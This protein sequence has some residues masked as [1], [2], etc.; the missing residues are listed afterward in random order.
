MCKLTLTVAI[1]NVQTEG[2][3]GVLGPLGSPLGA[4][5]LGG[6]GRSRDGG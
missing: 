5:G 4:A 1:R 3:Q 6:V 2:R